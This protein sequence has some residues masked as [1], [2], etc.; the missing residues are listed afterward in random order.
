MKKSEGVAFLEGTNR[1][2]VDESSPAVS[3]P[4]ASTPDP[5][6]RDLVVRSIME[7][8]PSTAAKLATRLKLTPAAIRRHLGDLL[9]ENHLK[10]SEERVYGSRSRGRPAKVF[11]LTDTGRGDFY[12]AYDE[13]AIDALKFLAETGGPEAID[14]FAQAR[15]REVRE[16]FLEIVEANPET[17]AVQAL[18]ESLNA[19]GYVASSLPVRSGEQL[20]QH[21]CPVAHVAQEF[22]QLCQAETELFTELLGRPV[23][24]LA[25]IAEGDGVCTTHV[26]HARPGAPSN[27]EP[28]LSESTSTEGTI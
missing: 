16:R 27:T 15:V 2:D 17:S 9:E 28:K 1:R 20:C 23:Q 26:P 7:H 22:P 18:S 21:H 14:R 24:R 12:Q 3:A 8:G 19:D 11:S 4:G 10:A 25:T 5:S 6:T 13:L